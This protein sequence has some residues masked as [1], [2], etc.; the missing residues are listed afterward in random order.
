[1]MIVVYYS[2]P[3]HSAIVNTAK[4][5]SAFEFRLKSSVSSVKDTPSSGQPCCNGD[6]NPCLLGLKR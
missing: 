4:E 3:L 6:I 2:Q 1:M 5:G